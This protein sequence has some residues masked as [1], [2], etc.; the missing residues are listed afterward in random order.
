M[1][2]LTIQEFGEFFAAVNGH[3]PFAWQQRLLERV[4]TEGSWP[5]VI[6]SP[7]GT[8]KS[9]V[10]DVHVFAVALAAHGQGPAVPRRLVVTV[11]RRALVDGHWEHA[12]R[13]RDQL[14]E[15]TEG[16]L[17]RVRQGL[18]AVDPGR[19]DADQP[20][21]IVSRV[22]GGERVNRDWVSHPAACQVIAAT[23]DMIGSRLL[24]RG[25]ASSRHGRSRE[26][27]LLA[28]DTAFVLDEAHLNRQLL[29][30][31][32]R[33][34]QL[35]ES[36]PETVGVEPLQV[37]AMTATPSAGDESA[38]GVRAQDLSGP[39]ASP[40]L[41]DRLL[42][43]KPVTMVASPALSPGRQSAKQV[44]EAAKAFAAATLDTLAELREQQAEGGAVTVACIVN[45][46]RLAVAVSAQIHSSLDDNG[47]RPAVVTLVG[48][49]R[50]HDLESLREQHGGL[51]SLAGDAGVDVVV[52]TQTIEVG[53]DMDF[54][55]LITELAPGSALAQR[56]GRGNRSGRRPSARVV[57][58]RPDGTVS[59][60]GRLG[61]YVG[62]DLDAAS[63][64][65]DDCGADP[66]GL[67]PWRLHPQG[68][69]L[70]PP[71]A[72][73]RRAVIQRVEPWDVAD[74]ERTSDD[75]A[76]EPWLDLWLSDDLEPDLSVGFVVRQ[77]LPLDD[78]GS[79]VRQVEVTPPLDHEV[80]PAT[81]ADAREILKSKAAPNRLFVVRGD[82]VSAHQGADVGQ[83][84]LRPGDILVVDYVARFTCRGVVV[85]P[86]IADSKA[87][88]DVGESG[89]AGSRDR[90]VRL[91]RDTPLGR[92]LGGDAVDGLLKDVRAS[93]AE[94]ESMDDV[95]SD[96]GP[97]DPLDVIRRALAERTGDAT[98]R[99]V[100]LLQ[101]L[102][103][104]DPDWH[105]APNPAGSGAPVPV[106]FEDWVVVRGRDL[107]ASDDDEI[108]TW[109][110]QGGRAVDLDEHQ[111]AV[112]REAGVLADA[113]GVA[114]VVRHALV[115]AGRL[116]DEGKRDER[117]Q[118]SLR[119]RPQDH[120]GRVLAKSGMK[121]RLRIVKARMASGLPAD[122]RHEQL[123][124]A[125]AWAGLESADSATRDLVTRLV[126]TSH[127]RGRH[128][129]P[130]VGRELAP[131]DQDA[132]AVRE[133]FDEAQ[134]ELVLDR[135][136]RRHGPWGCAYL[137]ALLRAADGEVSRRGS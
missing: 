118:R 44:T 53:V 131:P 110:P 80:F 52:A 67:A 84:A 89:R 43:P 103:A 78:V 1:T 129:F 123:S 91:G 101:A 20:P 6:D 117:F 98:D 96:Q 75:L 113:V 128:E 35:V 132:D 25:Y 83:F 116:H 58:L 71:P 7:T 19:H 95:P 38:E 107:R 54:A 39:E 77:G 99:P 49:M 106:G 135:T 114:P 21:L 82:E 11:D 27:G 31:L 105:M 85:T 23:P 97:P 121:D 45:T 3:P 4:A 33:V 111:E 74:W 65:L 66:R 63:R 100:A 40:L 30:T 29:A 73:S 125:M 59:G 109:N 2:D 93:Q 127:G 16:I 61:P 76:A 17:V 14:A 12:K 137:E 112:A 64:W 134:W 88:L 18:Q 133:L 34:R 55:A 119:W 51:F 79:A 81:L 122:W 37:V 24:F 120:P 47:E 62:A 104:G 22:R 57:V 8:G 86:D 94:A 72:A 90:W 48:R 28:F 56:A 9:S 41:A 108:Q 136:D 26:A 15:A 5:Q 50:P 46:V 130:H 60:D 32:R 36:A 69:G 70:V 92:A 13:L 124:A 87:P 68:D 115:Q 102:L 10:V 42:R 126:G